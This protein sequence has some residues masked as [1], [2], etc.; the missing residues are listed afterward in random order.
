[1]TPEQFCYWLQG[2]AETDTVPSDEQWCTV[3]E[4]LDTVFI[5]TTPVAVDRV[6]RKARKKVLLTELHGKSLPPDTR[7]T[8]QA[9]FKKI[10]DEELKEQLRP[11]RPV[12]GPARIC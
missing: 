12:R 1:M 4:H 5:P 2:F 9:E 6:A 10:S 11:F 7:K 3:R 8:L